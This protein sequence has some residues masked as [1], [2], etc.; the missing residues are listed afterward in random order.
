MKK[1]NIYKIAIY[2]LGGCGI[3]ILNLF[4]YNI[5]GI[6]IFIIFIGIAWWLNRK[7]EEIEAYNESIDQINAYEE[8]IEKYYNEIQ[9]IWPYKDKEVTA[10][11]E[12]CYNKE[13]KISIHTIHLE[14]NLDNQEKPWIINHIE[15][16]IASTYEAKKHENKFIAT[17]ED[18]II[19]LSKEKMLLNNEQTIIFDPSHELVKEANS[20]IKKLLP[21]K[22]ITTLKKEHFLTDQE[23]WDTLPKYT[24]GLSKKGFECKEINLAKLQLEKFFEE[25]DGDELI[26]KNSI[27]YDLYRKNGDFGYFGAFGDVDF[28]NFKTELIKHKLNNPKF[29]NCYTDINSLT[30]WDIQISHGVNEVFR[31]FKNYVNKNTLELIPVAIHNIESENVILFQPKTYPIESNLDTTG[32]LNIQHAKNEASVR[33]IEQIRNNVNF[34]VHSLNGRICINIDDKNFISINEEVLE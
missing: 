5:I 14:C 7:S 27:F 4:N 19:I 6:L 16:G 2:I 12:I 29:I 13:R 15:N 25:N 11:E 18:G 33:A 17:T 30:E 24:F 31:L 28:R 22:K 10:F 21:E 23:Y 20:I 34:S 1:T 9:D 3:F 32:L 26:W 8:E